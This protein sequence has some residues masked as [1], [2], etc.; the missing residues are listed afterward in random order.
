MRVFSDV[1]FISAARVIPSASAVL[2]EEGC[3]VVLLKPQFEA[4]RQEVGKGGVIKDPKVHA[5]VLGRFIVWAVDHGFRVKDL[6][7]S[8]ITGDSGNRE[9]F[10]LLTPVPE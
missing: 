9:F 5:R 4:R 6:T 8:P 7:P 2:K 3:I 10:V 1:S